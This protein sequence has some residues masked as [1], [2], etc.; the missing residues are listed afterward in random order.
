M[1]T[2]QKILAGALIT[3]V[4]TGVVGYFK[5]ARADS[6]SRTI[7]RNGITVGIEKTRYTKGE[8]ITFWLKNER[9]VKIELPNSAPWVIEEKTITGWKA[10]FSPVAAQVV[11]PIR[12][13]EKI[14]WWWQQLT[15]EKDWVGQGKYR[16]GFPII[17]DLLYLR[18]EIVEA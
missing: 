4:G 6:K 17:E 11:I 8:N 9:T 18:F 16:V 15:H 14:I 1:K 13:G 7:T 5:L 2:R 12:S 3:L 10:I